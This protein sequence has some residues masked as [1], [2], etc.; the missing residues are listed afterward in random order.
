M[1]G[2]KFENLVDMFEKSTEKYADNNLFGVKK[3]GRYQWLS[4]RE[5]REQVDAFR[6]GLASLGVEKGDTVAIISNNRPEWAIGAYATYSVGARWVPMYEAQLKKDWYY[7]AN[8]SGAKVLIVPDD[9]TH[10]KVESFLEEIETLEHIVTISGERGDRWADLIEKGQE[11]EVPSVQPDPDDIC[12]LIYTSGTTGNPKGVLLSHRNLTSNVNAVHEVFPMDESDSSLSFLPWAHSFGQTAELHC[13]L[14]YGAALGLAESVQTIIENIAEVRPTLLFSV[15]RIFNRI[16]DAVHKKM[17]AEGG[18]KKK[19]FDKTLDVAQ[20]RRKLADQGRSSALLDI[21][22]KVL[23]KLVGQKIRDRFGG[24]LR[25]A[26]SGGAALSTEVGEFIDDLGITVYE[27]YGLTET[28]PIVSCNRPGAR[29]IGSI[30]KPIPGV[31]VKIAPIDIAPEGQG[32]IVVYGP[33]VMKGYHGLPEANAKVFT[34]DGGF[35]T[36]DMGRIDDDGFVWITGR[37]KEQY[38][39]ENGKYVV[40]SPLEEKLKLSGF[41]ANCMIDG[42]NRPY[43]IAVIVPDMESLRD[44]ADAEGISYD[45]D[46]DLIEKEPV[47]AL[48]ETE[49]QKYS[50]DWKGYERPRKFVLTAED[51]TVENGMLTPSMKIKRRNVLEEYGDAID[52]LYKE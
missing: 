24:R 34:D 7:I 52:A 27:G 6:G 48:I 39:L 50:T 3:D 29:K 42:T 31:Q 28:S 35:R 16:Y 49:I 14:S 5:I 36:G 8:D 41:I 25:Y 23:D 2:E 30:G 32:E 10:A 44:W 18:L 51:F 13:M 11:T 19:L 26:F 12:G 22:F 40:P 20:K 46:D 17:A 15:P 33:N 4:Y 1:A 21:Q 9:E 47:S 38:K 45:S 37:V 43:N